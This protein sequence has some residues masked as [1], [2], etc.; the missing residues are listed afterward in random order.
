[1]KYSGTKKPERS[2]KDKKPGNFAFLLLF[3]LFVSV[4]GRASN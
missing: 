1:M 4:L 2:E 3:E